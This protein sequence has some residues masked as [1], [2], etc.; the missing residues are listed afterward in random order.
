MFNASLITLLI[1]QMLKILLITPGS[2]DGLFIA[3]SGF[4]IASA[5]VDEEVSNKL[6]V[7]SRNF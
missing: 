4:E 2:L 7:D 3:V 5:L 1:N 6:R